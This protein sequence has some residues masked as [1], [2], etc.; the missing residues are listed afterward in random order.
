MRQPT[1]YER[2]NVSP[3]ATSSEIRRAYR[4]LA[5]TLHPD[6]SRPMGLDPLDGDSTLVDDTSDEMAE[7]N[8]AYAVLKDPVRRAMY[9][10]SLYRAEKPMPATAPRRR[11]EADLRKSRSF[12]F[13]W[14]PRHTVAGAGVLVLAGLT[15]WAV[16]ALTGH[17]DDSADASIRQ[18]IEAPAK[19]SVA[20]TP[21]TPVT[22]SANTVPHPLDG[23][24]AL[25]LTVSTALAKNGP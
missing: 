21:S 24:A 19:T 5:M 23:Q 9:D 2:L 20:A 17:L 8:A 7:V 16:L 22:P 12:A 18:A 4:A 11:T 13:G 1:H 10:A 15:A 25:V 14:N 6:R 3:T